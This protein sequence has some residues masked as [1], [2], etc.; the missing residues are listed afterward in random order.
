MLDG[1]NPRD[2]TPAS[3]V[4]DAE[5]PTWILGGPQEYAWAPDSKEI[6]Y[7]T[8]L[9]KDPAAS[10]NND[11]FTLRLD[12]PGAKAVRVST[13]PGS[14]DEPEYS[15]DGKWLAFRSQARQDLRGIGFG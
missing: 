10:T 13:R 2:L 4:G 14:D 9:D 7:V 6:A 11:V 5:T 15:P 8:N 3:A 12:E 1:A